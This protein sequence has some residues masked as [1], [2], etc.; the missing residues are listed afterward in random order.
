[1]QIPSELDNLLVGY[2]ISQQ[3]AE[4]DNSKVQAVTG[5]PAPSTIKELQWFLGFPNFY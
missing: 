4:I 1:M 5:W 3:E 2:L